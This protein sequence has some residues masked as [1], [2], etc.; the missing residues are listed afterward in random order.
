MQEPTASQLLADILTSPWARNMSLI[1]AI[2]MATNRI[3]SYF[4]PMVRGAIRK[5]KQIEALWEDYSIR[6][7]GPYRI[8]SSDSNLR[9]HSYVPYV[10]EK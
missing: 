5:E 7:G 3:T 2:V 8:P 1:A 10:R 4:A 9:L 6:Y